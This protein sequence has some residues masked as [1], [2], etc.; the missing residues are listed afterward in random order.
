MTTQTF[1]AE[2][3]LDNDAGTL[4]KLGEVTNVGRPRK[5]RESMD[6]THHGSPNATREYMKSKLKTLETF[7]V[8]FRYDPGGATEAAAEAAVENDNA[9]SYKTV[10]RN[11]AGTGV[12]YSGEGLVLSFEPGEAPIDGMFEGS[13]TI[14]PTGAYA[15]DEAA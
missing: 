2:F 11:E 8:T 5:T 10:W 3:W 12:E 4:T 15:I 1:G 13:L 14:Q 6:K 9:V 7:T